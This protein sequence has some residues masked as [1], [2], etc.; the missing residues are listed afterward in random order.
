M[1]LG[2]LSYDEPSIV[3]FCSTIS[4]KMEGLKTMC[5][6]RSKISLGDR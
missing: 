6:K 2:K 4:W 5:G 1:R 3:I